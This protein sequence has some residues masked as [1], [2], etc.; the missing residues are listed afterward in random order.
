[1][2]ARWCPDETRFERCLVVPS[3]RGVVVSPSPLSWVVHM[4][5]QNGDSYAR[6]RLPPTTQRLAP[7][8]ADESSA[9]SSG[10]DDDDDDVNYLTARTASFRIRETPQARLR[11]LQWE[12]AQLEKELQSPP[13]RGDAAVG[14]GRREPRETGNLRRR[15]VNAPPAGELL[16]QLAALQST[17]QGL[18]GTAERRTAGMGPI[19]ADV[20]RGI[21]ESA[22][23]R[24]DVDEAEVEEVATAGGGGSRR[25]NKAAEL[26]RRLDVLEK[27]IGTGTIDEVRPSPL[28]LPSDS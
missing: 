7:H 16:K 18:E 1:M 23:R 28:S 14:E 15:K 17:A 10:D 6:P 8:D 3:G 5:R 26:D 27:R 4:L 11:R 22:S 20:V 24:E 9:S 25:G 12:M 13:F 2:R 19:M 21:V